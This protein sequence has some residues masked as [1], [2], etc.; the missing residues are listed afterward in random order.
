MI[1]RPQPAGPPEAYTTYALTSP[2][3]ITV[4][5]AC[6]DVDCAAWRHG[7]E[8]TVD[9]RTPLGAAQ[10]GYVRER[11]RRTFREMY[12]EG[13][14]TVFRFDS[15]QRCFNEHHTRLEAYFRTPGDWR[16]QT[17]ETFVHATPADWQEDFGEHQQ[18]IADQIQQG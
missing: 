13:G 10:A 8:T 5:A 9:E 11:S 3:D 7:W 6:R 15:G 2:T 17:G 12:P 18:M 16:A 14:L 1:N 4:P